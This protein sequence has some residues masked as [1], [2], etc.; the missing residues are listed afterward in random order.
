MSLP[1]ERYFKACQKYLDSLLKDGQKISPD[2]HLLNEFYLII[3]GDNFS[4]SQN[5]EPEKSDSM[6]LIDV[7][8]LISYLFFYKP[9]D[10]FSEINNKILCIVLIKK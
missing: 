2:F 9:T 4:P 6:V 5:S 10:D 1:P 7:L 3:E 8:I